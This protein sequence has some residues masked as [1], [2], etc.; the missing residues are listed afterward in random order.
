MKKVIIFLKFYACFKLITIGI[1][2]SNM[3][4]WYFTSIICPNI[5]F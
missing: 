5:H 3:N 1:C 2:V 4:M